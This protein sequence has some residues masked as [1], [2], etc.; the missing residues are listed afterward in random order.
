MADMGIGA[1]AF[2]FCRG[3]RGKNLQRAGDKIGLR[4]PLA[5]Q[6]KN[7]PRGVA[8]TVIQ[9][10]SGIA[11]GL[12]FSHDGRQGV[13]RS[14]VMGYHMLALREQSHAG[15]VLHFVVDVGHQGVVDDQCEGHQALFFPFM[16]GQQPT[17]AA[18]L[19]SQGLRHVARQLHK[20][21]GAGRGR[22]RRRHFQ[23]GSL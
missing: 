10:L 13:L 9:L 5:E 19:G 4:Q 1:L 8:C 14:E 20:K 2:N 11:L 18:H 23:D 17:H 16:A 22:H 7:H 3:A 6:Y 12:Q 21:F 15:R